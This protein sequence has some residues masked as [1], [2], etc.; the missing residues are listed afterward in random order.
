MPK[1]DLSG[2]AAVVKNLVSHS[3][4]KTKSKAALNVQNKRLFSTALKTFVR[5]KVATSILRTIE[6]IGGLDTFVIRQPNNLLSKKAKA[7]QKRIK[8]V[9]QV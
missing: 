8:K 1:C 5:L 6:K 2:K 7:I 4:I 3:N 9:L